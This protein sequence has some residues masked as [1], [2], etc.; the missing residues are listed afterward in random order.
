VR[1]EAAR[2]LSTWPNNWPEDSGVAEPLLTLA[3][4][5]RKTSYQVLGLRGYLQYVQGDKQL[6]D[7]AKVGKV[8][9]VLEFIKRPEERRL[10]IGVVS[11]TPTAGALEILIAF[12][13]EEAV[14]DDAC[15]AVVK[16]A[17][18][19]TAPISKEQRQ[20]ALQTVVEK[21]TQDATRNKAKE[22]LK[23]M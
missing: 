20:Q 22:L 15:S 2:T 6:K 11:G 23:A 21:T 5:S 3:K 19:K 13:A 16:L 14:A 9:E 12:A 7:E 4:Y 1:D 17:E 18:L 10:A 8:K